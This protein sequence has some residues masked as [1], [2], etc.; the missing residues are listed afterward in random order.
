MK[1]CIIVVTHKKYDMPEFD[2]YLPVHAGR[3]GKSDLGFQGDNIGDNI[4]DKNLYYC[5]LTALYWAWNNLE[6]DYLGLVHYR[7]YFTL[8]R[9]CT[10]LNHVISQI[11]IENL[12]KNVDIILPK[13]KRYFQTVKEHYIHCIK[14]R[15]QDHK[16]HMKLLRETIQDLHPDYIEFFDEVMNGHEAHMLNMFI[17]K[18]EDADKYC[19]WMFEILF[20]LEKRILNNNVNFERIMGAF[21]EFLLDVWIKKNKKSFKEVLLY[22]TEKDLLKKLKW[23]LSRKLTQ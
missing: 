14:S 22:E 17:M 15:V 19:E 2:V 16:V 21:S 20:E 3:E 8:R 13:K 10:S 18:K 4:S 11:E 23:A 12:L 9:K 7:R 5:E 6:C 1:T